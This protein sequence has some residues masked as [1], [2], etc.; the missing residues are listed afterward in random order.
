ME[1]KKK[2]K[3]R[4]GGSGGWGQSQ[5]HRETLTVSSKMGSRRRNSGVRRRNE[6]HTPEDPEEVRP[7]EFWVPELSGLLPPLSGTASLHSPSF[8]LLSQVKPPGPLSPLCPVP[9]IPPSALI[10]GVGSHP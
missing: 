3:S 8:F 9:L 10:T 7:S 6:G 5:L 1:K 4:R 2:K